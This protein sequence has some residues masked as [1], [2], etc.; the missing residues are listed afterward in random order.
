MISNLNHKL[1]KEFA[2]I[3]F[4]LDNL[5]DLLEDIGTNLSDLDLYAVD[6]LDM[7]ALAMISI[8]CKK[9]SKPLIVYFVL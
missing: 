6:Q 9:L 2:I 5:L 3:H 4:L 7:K 1:S 8:Y